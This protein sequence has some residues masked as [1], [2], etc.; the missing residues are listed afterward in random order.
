MAK[1]ML[2]SSRTDRFLAIAYNGGNGWECSSCRHTN[3]EYQKECASCGKKRTKAD[4]P[5]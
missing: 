5:A 3:W 2:T 1:K 4:E